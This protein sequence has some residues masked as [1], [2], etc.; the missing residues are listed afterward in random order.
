ME[1]IHY[2]LK[3]E[4][5]SIHPN[6]NKLNQVDLLWQVSTSK[7]SNNTMVDQLRKPIPKMRMQSGCLKLRSWTFDPVGIDVSHDGMIIFCVL[8][9]NVQYSVFGCD[10]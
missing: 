5:N 7:K 8:H 1:M 10:M 2:L 6:V 3:F 4:I 9:R